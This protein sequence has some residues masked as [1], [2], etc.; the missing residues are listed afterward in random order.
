MD[1]F[2]RL[3]HPA[4]AIR[5]C[6]PAKTGEPMSHM[7]PD[8]LSAYPQPLMKILLAFGFGL[9]IAALL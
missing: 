7:L 5:I 2:P 8:H 9:A 6:I 4:D 1:C 3:P